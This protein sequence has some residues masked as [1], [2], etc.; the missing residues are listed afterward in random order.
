MIATKINTNTHDAIQLH[1]EMR[2]V[3]T[4]RRS[5]GDRSDIT[6]G[7]IRLDALISSRGELPA[8]WQRAVDARTDGQ[9]GI[10]GEILEERHRQDEQWGG[11]AHDDNHSAAEWIC[12]IVKHVGKAVA[13]AESKDGTALRHRLIVI[14]ALVVAA[15]ESYDRKVT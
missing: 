4:I 2:D 1:R 7:F 10:F 11:P 3:C 14:A 9:V 6:T 15:I 12:W 5:E 8:D 13:S